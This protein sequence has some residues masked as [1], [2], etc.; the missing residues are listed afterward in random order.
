ML[1]GAWSERM[2]S[3]AV[4]QPAHRGAQRAVGPDRVAGG[5]TERDPGHYLLFLRPCFP[6]LCD[7]AD[8]AM[9]LVVFELLGLLSAF[10]AFDATGFEV[11]LL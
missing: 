11:V 4:R 9:L 1:S 2:R 8:P 6:E 3:P 5:A 7:T 10:A